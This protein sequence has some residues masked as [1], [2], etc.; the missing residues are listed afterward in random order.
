[1]I[2]FGMVSGGRGAP[3]ASAD[4]TSV[5]MTRRIGAIVFNTTDNIAISTD[6]VGRCQV[7]HGEPAVT[8]RR[9]PS[10]SIK[11]PLRLK[12]EPWLDCPWRPHAGQCYRQRS[13]ML[14]ARWVGRRTERRDRAAPASAT[15]TA[16]RARSRLLR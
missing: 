11:A 7:T 12:K 10:Y 9:D 13:E 16:A 5:R 14:S 15:P 4:A 6:A 1:M 3:S 8:P 2:D